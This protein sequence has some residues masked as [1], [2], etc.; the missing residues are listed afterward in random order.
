LFKCTGFIIKVLFIKILIEQVQEQRNFI[1]SL[2]R[3]EECIWRNASEEVHLKKWVWRR[4]LEDTSSEA[5]S[6][7]AMV[8]RST[9]A[10]A[11]SPELTKYDVRSVQPRTL[12]P[13]SLQLCLYIKTRLTVTL[14]QTLFL[15][16]WNGFEISSSKEKYQIR[17]NINGEE[18]K[19]QARQVDVTAKF[20]TSLKSSINRDEDLENKN[21]LDIHKKKVNTLCKTSYTK[22]QQLRE[23]FQLFIS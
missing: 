13:P 8:I 10:E 2:K 12:Q 23:F 5:R 9:S 3:L 4:A 18:S 6:S 19:L 20:S 7:E 14:L 22:H 11:T 21:D 15:F 16:K 17:Q 1:R